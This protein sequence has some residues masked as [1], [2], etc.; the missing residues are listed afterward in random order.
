[1]RR[2]GFWQFAIA[3]PI[4]FLVAGLGG[5]SSSSPIHTVTY[6]V[7]ASITISP[8]PNLSMEIGTNQVFLSK[9]SQFDQDEHYRAR[10]L[11][12]Q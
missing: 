9:H 11:P 4:L 1:M 10:E 6:P 8:A 7:P 3:V 2:S 12:V 5:C